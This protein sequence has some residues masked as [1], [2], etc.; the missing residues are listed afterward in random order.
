MKDNAYGVRAVERAVGVLAAL[1]TADTPQTLTEI[2]AGARLSV[3]TTFRLLRTLQSEGLVSLGRDGGRYTLGPRILEFGHAY[4]RQFD[5]VTVARP[6]LVAARN[7]VNE[8]AGLAVR[9]GDSWVPIV[10]AEATQPI[11]RV[12]HPGEPTPLYASGTGK[13]LL[14]GEPDEEIAA[15]LARTRLEP[16]STTTVTTPETLWTQIREIR[17]LGYSCSVNERGAGGVGV[18]APVRGH[19]GRTVAAV[20]VAA[21]ASRFTP[22]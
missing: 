5:I 18:S 7:R 22:E 2:A 9:S 13:L 6:F 11:R 21:P 1:A 20:L 4:L 3:P 10:S 8:T 15:Y 14:A 19:D 17:E 12:M 16:F